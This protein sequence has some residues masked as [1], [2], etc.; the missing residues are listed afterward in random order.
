MRDLHLLP[1]HAQIHPVNFSTLSDQPLQTRPKHTHTP[2]TH[3]SLLKRT[4]SLSRGAATH[5]SLRRPP[6]RRAARAPAL[7]RHGH[8]GRG[9]FAAAHDR[10]LLPNRERLFSSVTHRRNRVR[11]AQTKHTTAAPAARAEQ[12]QRQGA[13]RR[14]LVH[15]QL[16]GEPRRD[17]SGG[18]C[19]EEITCCL[20]RLA[21]G[22]RLFRGCQP[23]NAQPRA[24]ETLQLDPALDCATLSRATAGESRCSITTSPNLSSCPLCSPPQKTPNTS[25]DSALQQ[26][27]EPRLVG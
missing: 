5:A 3:V 25:T 13:Q 6:R 17:V 4:T 26:A 20:H 24:P 15:V 7:P 11:C 22:T 16:Q 19:L 14:R 9:E 23:A 27:H 1:A 10:A 18:L 12:R 8:G 21:A 2:R